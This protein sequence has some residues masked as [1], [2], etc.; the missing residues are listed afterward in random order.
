MQFSY[1]LP[2]LTASSFVTRRAHWSCRLHA[3]VPASTSPL[4]ICLNACH[5]T[6]HI[7]RTSQGSLSLNSQVL[8]TCCLPG[9][10]TRH[11]PPQPARA[12]PWSP[13]ESPAVPFCHQEQVFPPGLH[14]NFSTLSQAS[15]VKMFS[16]AI[17]LQGPDTSST[18]FLVLCAFGPLGR[19]GRVLVPELPI[20]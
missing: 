5:P 10:L 8:P 14:E 20:P 11:M 1:F 18:Q 7:L 3:P 19:Q 2:V 6:A 15:F 12:S 16:S 9:S 17:C 13:L 4:R